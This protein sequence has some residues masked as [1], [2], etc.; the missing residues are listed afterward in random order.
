MQD[1]KEFEANILDHGYVRLIESWGN[2]QRII[3]SARMSTAKGFLGWGPK[4]DGS[5]GDEKLLRFLWEKKHCYDSETEVLVQGRGFVPWSDVSL[6]DKLGCYDRETDSLVYEVP[7]EIISQPYRGDLYRVDHGGVDLLVTPEHRM[8]VKTIVQ[9]DTNKQGWSNNWSLLS[10]NELGD[11]AMVR[12]RKHAMRREAPPLDLSAFPAH[13]DPRELLRL[14]GFFLGDGFAGRDSG[15][16]RNG[17]VFHLKKRRK[18]EWLAEVCAGV[19]WEMEELSSV[20]VRADGVTKI[21]RDLFYDENNEKRMPAFLSD[22]SAED[23]SALL[24][25]LRN[26][27]GSEKR[28]TWTYSTTSS[29]L[30]QAI[31]IIA[32]H[33]GEVVHLGISLRSEQKPEHKPLHRLMVLSRMRE[34]VINQSKRNTSRVPYDG[35]VYC[36]HTRTGVLVV[37]RNGKIVLSGN[38]TPFEMAGVVIE[39]KAPIFVFREWHR[40]RTQSYNEMSARYIPL[41]NEN[42]VPTVERLMINS[43]SNKQAGTVAGAEELT[44]D[45]AQRFRDQLIAMYAAQESLYHEALKSGVPK[46][47]ARVHL[48]VGRYS[49]M[50]ASTNLRNWLAFLTLRDAPDAQWEIQQYAKAVASVV[51]LLH[52]RTYDIYVGGR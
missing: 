22:L 46:E 9:V 5:P 37:R 27:D 18:I 38:C 29:K 13:D 25:G 20:V 10:A 31:Q 32:L 17:I 45:T 4:G 30:A 47:L 51:K 49:V 24:D 28:S 43:K 3:E 23:A 36:A 19:G 34:P 42:Y 50:R 26:S 1:T 41:P 35:T 33:A 39:V 21:F 16:A 6:K 8:L 12:Y 15:T 7:L 48:P 11:R 44:E 2:D 14:I 40:H 52:P